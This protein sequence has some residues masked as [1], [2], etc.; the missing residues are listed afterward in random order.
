MRE[1]LDAAEGK[2]SELKNLIVWVRFT[3][4]GSFD[5]S[6]HEFIF[7]FKKGVAAHHNSFELGQHGR[8]RTKCR[9]LPVASPDLVATER[10]TLSGIRLRN[11]FN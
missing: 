10:Q 11:R 3:G 5:R 1:V 9:D 8:N 4:M 7:A 2:Y 6:R